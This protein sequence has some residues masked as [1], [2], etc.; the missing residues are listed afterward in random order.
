MLIAWELLINR[1]RVPVERAL[2][3][4]GCVVMRKVDSIGCPAFPPHLERTHEGVL[5]HGE[6]IWFV[7]RVIQKSLGQPWCYV[8]FRQ[9]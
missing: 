7:S 5:E 3:P 1:L 6:L 8:Y 2:D 4:P 9:S